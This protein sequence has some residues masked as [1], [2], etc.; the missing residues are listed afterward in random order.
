MLKPAS[1]AKTSIMIPDVKEC[2]AEVV[3][4]KSGKA[5]AKLVGFA[6]GK[7]K[8]NSLKKLISESLKLEMRD[9]VKATSTSLGPSNQSS[10]SC[11]LKALKRT[12]P[13]ATGLSEDEPPE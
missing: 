13:S 7:L 4:D 8:P 5:F 9:T 10:V 3:S 12:G 2:T 1:P 11:S 6:S